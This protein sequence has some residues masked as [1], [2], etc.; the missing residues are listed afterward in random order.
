MTLPSKWVLRY[1]A[2]AQLV[3]TWSKDPST[4]VACVLVDERR[5]VISTGYNGFPETVEDRPEWYADR[6]IKYPLVIHAEVNAIANATRAVA[7][8]TAFLTHPPCDN[9]AKTLIAHGITEIHFVMP[10]PDLL[11]RWQSSL[12]AARF[13][14]ERS[15]ISLVGWRLEADRAPNVESESVPYSWKRVG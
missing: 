11:S 8:S 14:A 15:G 10:D 9:C 12:D 6:T 7:G 2:L 13:V 1:I 4:K 3:A 5:R